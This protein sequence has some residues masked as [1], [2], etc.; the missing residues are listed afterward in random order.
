MKSNDAGQSAYFSDLFRVLSDR[1]KHSTLGRL[2]FANAPLREHLSDVFGGAHGKKGAFLSDPTFEAVFGWQKA[3]STMHSLAESGLLEKRLVTAMDSPPPELADEYRF[4]SGQSPYSHQEAAWRLLTNDPA[5]S[6]VVSSG[7]GSGKTEC[8][9]VPVLNDLV[10]QTRVEKD[11]LVG[12][13]ALFLYPLNALINSQRERLRAWT[14]GLDGDVRFALYNGNTPEVLPAKSKN[15]WSCEVKDRSSLRASPPAILVTNASMLEY[16][17]VRTVDRPILEQSQGK[18]RWV[19]LDEAHTYVGSQAAE[20][21]LLIRRVLLAFG[22][23]PEQVRFVATSATIG[24]PSGPAGEQLRR[25]LAE[26]GGVPY[27]RVHLVA[28]RRDIPEHVESVAKSE[29]SLS[30]LAAIDAGETV[31]EA[32]YQALVNHPVARAIRGLFAAGEGRPAVARLSEVCAAIFGDKSNG[33]TDQQSEALAWLDLLSG[34]SSP[35][36][37]RRGESHCFLP[38]RAHL[39]HQTVSG[40]WAC[41]DPECPEKKGSALDHADWPFG[42]TYLEPRKHC[43]CGSPVYPVVSCDECGE[44]ALMAAA[45]DAQQLIHVPDRAAIDEFELDIEAESSTDDQEDGDEDGTDAEEQDG[46]FGKVLVFNRSGEHV[47]EMCVDRE[48]RKIVANSPDVLQL[49]VREEDRGGL[50]CPSCKAVEQGRSLFR[51]ARI[52]APFVVSMVM[53]TLLE[54]APDGDQAASHPGRGRRLLTF[55]DSRQGTAR[56]AARLQQDA[57]RSRVRGLIYHLVLQAGQA[58]AAGEYEKISREIE[59][60]DKAHQASPNDGLRE[61]IDR[62]RAELSALEE[63]APVMF[64]E[65]AKLLASQ[66][67]DFNWMHRHYA[68]VAPEVFSESAGPVELASMFLIREFGRRPKRLNNLESMGLVAVDYPALAKIER[69]PETIQGVADLTI[70]EWRTLLKLTLDFFIRSGGSLAIPLNWRAWLGVPFPQ[71]QIVASSEAELGPRQRRWPRFAT[72]KQRTLII[73]LIAH[74]LQFDMAAPTTED[75]IDAILQAA[76]GDLVRLGLLKLGDDGRTLPLDALAF[77]VIDTA[78]VC[79]VTRRFLDTTLRGVTPYLPHHASPEVATCR[80]VSMPVYDK[81][82]SDVTDDLDRIKTARA[83]LNAQPQ[84]ADLRRE[85]LWGT[86]HDMVL[87]LSLYYTTAEHSAQQDSKTLDGYEKAFKAGDINLLSCSTTMEMGIDIGGISMVAMNNVPPHPSNYLQRAGRAGRRKE[88]RSLALTVCKS[89]PHDQGVFAN[90]RWAFDTA[91]PAPRVALDSPVITA[92]HINSYFLSKFLLG[93]LDASGGEQLKLACGAFFLGDPSVARRFIAW[94]RSGG[95]S[96][97]DELKSGLAEICRHSIFDGYPVNRLLDG[98]AD[99]LSAINERW[100]RTHDNLCQEEESLAR[101]GS[102]REPAVMAV[103]MQKERLKGEYLLRELAGEGFLPAYGFPTNITSFDNMTIGRF[104][105][106]Q[107]RRRSESSREDNRF[108]RRELASR[109]IVTALREYAPGSE[110]VMD[111]LMYRSAGVTLNWHI[112]ASEQGAKEIQEIRFAWRCSSCGSSGSALNLK[113]ALHCDQCGAEIKCHEKNLRQFLVP[114]GFAVDFYQDPSND[115]STQHFVP[116]EQ[117]WV[118]AEGDWAPLENP[119]LGRFRCTPR[120]HIFNQSRGVNG[121][122]YALCLECGRAEPMAPD[123]GLPDVFK[124]PHRKLRRARG[125]ELD[126]PGSFDSWKI[127]QEITLGSESWTDVLEIQLKSAAGIWLNDDAA[128][129]S[130]AV[131]LRDSL[132]ALIGVQAQELGCD[133]KPTAAENGAPCRSIVIYDRHA[134]GYAS[135]AYRF[136]VDLL[137]KAR[138]QLDCPAACDSACPHCILDFDQRFASERLDRHA[139]LRF[140]STEWMAALALPDQLQYFGPGTHMEYKPLLEA[141]WLT[142]SGSGIDKVRFFLGGGVDDWDLGPSPLREGAYR[143]A[144]HG[145]QVELVMPAPVL[146]HLSDEDRD[147]LAGLAAHPQ[148]ALFSTAAAVAV[149][150][151]NLIAEASGAK[152]S[153]VW[154]VRDAASTQFGPGWAEQALLVTHCSPGPE[155]IELKRIE[156][157][158]IRRD[159]PAVL[160]GDRELEVQDQLDGPL[161]KFGVRFWEVLSSEHPGLKALLGDE[162]DSLVELNYRD[163][164]LFTPIS[165]ALLA[166]VIDGLRAMVSQVRFDVPQVKIHT[167]DCRPAGVNQA[168]RKIWS[169][170]ADRDLRDGVCEAT[171]DYFGITA[172]VHSGDIHSV[173]H[174]R[175]LE[176]VF[177]SGKALTVRLDQGISYWRCGRSASAHQTFFDVDGRNI[178]AQVQQLAHLNVPVEGGTMPTQLFVKLRK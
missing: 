174:G 37:K 30:D 6:L 106:E 54:F 117:P 43:G 21:A 125:D 172:R 116:V 69:V 124:K 39:F 84:I 4:P 93:V 154:A 46:G 95:G 126:C 57:E 32:R 18:L 83:W 63:P 143:L 85:G 104:K 163:R 112:P 147:L 64:F 41:A 55:N 175:L 80:E 133:V 141:L 10:R 7:T 97:L 114:A 132:A 71:S 127:K 178:D 11:P 74:V 169:D 92:R 145:V 142:L 101:S 65:L 20:A 88:T 33:S 105:R 56:M 40:L 156:G 164:Y 113:G 134:A 120:G 123:R 19:I 96:D 168:R 12:V 138:E 166:Q 59:L 130:I 98:S 129:S 89:N 28:G 14:G 23:K 38:L 153:R 167:T 8:F 155:N 87:E 35:P 49:Q 79:P 137:G 91:L 139:A 173:G 86:L 26:V 108:Q 111:G 62:K 102:D 60:L 45:G 110:I 171:F 50:G 17:L 146:D 68:R 31:S 73:R 3:N 177:E 15:E 148:I 159:P 36:A 122:G 115:I 2:G 52:G 13:Q 25:F 70:D 16:M 99:A 94:C 109:D 128:A 29:L 72:G 47:G 103:R 149:G 67:S 27:D 76:W 44:V 158:Q 162:S 77:R 1:A 66:G 157:S 51:S 119:A 176:L 160:E 136:V 82:F 61:L 170:W 165:V 9:L 48:T 140:L 34:T 42:T 144:S 118:D 135:G 152:E 131:A 161:Q 121:T 81:P 58:S 22:V 100:L 5:E 107:Q 53:P 78:W 75:R 150:G 151:G 24:D 90:S